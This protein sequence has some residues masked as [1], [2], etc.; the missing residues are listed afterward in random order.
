MTSIT[1][2]FVS[3]NTVLSSLAGSVA[4]WFKTAAAPETASTDAAGVPS[5]M[6]LYRMAGSGDSVGP[7]V[8]AALAK[9]AK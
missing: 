6:S 1:F 5:L 4:R 2:P 8:A 3:E 7:E 9:M